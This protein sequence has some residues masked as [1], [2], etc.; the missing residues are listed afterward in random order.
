M[1]EL[2]TAKQSV[3]LKYGGRD[4]QKTRNSLT[5][6]RTI[7]LVCQESKKLFADARERD[8]VWATDHGWIR[9]E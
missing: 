1:R 9:P 6:P 3:C 2:R 5:G 4:G 8:A 7:V